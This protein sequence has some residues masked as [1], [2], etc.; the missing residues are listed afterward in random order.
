MGINTLFKSVTHK[1][2]SVL[3]LSSES[4]EIIDGLETA[5][6]YLLAA[7]RSGNKLLL[8]GNGGSAADA[9][10]IAAEL[11]GRFYLERRALVGA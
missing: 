4:T 6:G 8:C 9:Q 5:A 2:Q 10:H 11:V 7:F 3:R 1:H